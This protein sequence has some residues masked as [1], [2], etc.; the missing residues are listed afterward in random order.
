MNGNM[1]LECESCDEDVLQ[2]EVRWHNERPYHDACLR[3]IRR[4][5][6]LR[7]HIGA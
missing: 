6:I 2:D 1:E 3:A 5:E 7:Q 4:E